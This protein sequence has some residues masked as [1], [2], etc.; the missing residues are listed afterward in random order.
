MKTE[1]KDRAAPTQF[2]IGGGP[3]G[4]NGLLIHELRMR[5]KH[6]MSTVLIP[7]KHLQKGDGKIDR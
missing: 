2:F 7:E 6:I 1:P 5:W 3:E 4:V